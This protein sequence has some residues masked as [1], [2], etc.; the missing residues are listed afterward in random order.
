[1]SETLRLYGPPD[2]EDLYSDLDS[3]VEA[4]VD[5]LA[6]VNVGDVFTFAEHDV[7]PPRYHF[8]SADHVL[9]EIVEWVCDN[10]EIDG[11]MAEEFEAVCRSA[12]AVA[13]IEFALDAIASK[14]RYRMANN[15]LRTFKVRITAVREHGIVDWEEAVSEGPP[16]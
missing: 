7:H 6:T 10:G 13:A 5:D 11:D 3:A 9:D 4:Y 1:V 2:A 14:I 12:P 16:N 8:P 15:L